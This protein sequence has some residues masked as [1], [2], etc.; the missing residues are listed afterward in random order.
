DA[1]FVQA[2]SGRPAAPSGPT[3][4][5]LPPRPTLGTPP[6]DAGA[7]QEWLKEER[8]RLEEYLSKQFGVLQHRREELAAWQSRIEA[9]LV[10]REQ[11]LN[12]LQRQCA[13]QEESLAQRENAVAAITTELPVLESRLTNLRQQVTE[14]QGLAD[15]NRDRKSTRLNSS[16]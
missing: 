14:Q 8:Q 1:F 15:K 9:A 13:A 5:P 4:M 12:R 7:E 3:P 2:F 10:A 11:E 16:H 6:A